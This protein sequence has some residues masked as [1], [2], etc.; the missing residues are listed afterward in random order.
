MQIVL[1]KFDLKISLESFF[2]LDYENTRTL[3]ST[4]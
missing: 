3:E 2:V 4:E 1:N